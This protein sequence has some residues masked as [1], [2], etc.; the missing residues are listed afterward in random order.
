MLF[1]DIN[2]WFNNNLLNLNFSETHN[3]EFRSI[4]HYNVN[5]HIQHNHNYISD[6]SETKFLGLIIDDTLSWKQH[7][8]H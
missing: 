4:K 8:D 7:I 3:L 6:T 1:N 2:T 5:M